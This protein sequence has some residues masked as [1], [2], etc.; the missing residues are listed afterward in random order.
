MH[1][2]QGIVIRHGW[3]GVEPLADLRDTCLGLLCQTA[4]LDQ[5]LLGCVARLVDVELAHPV[6]RAGVEE[7]DPGDYLGRLMAYARMTGWGRRQR[8]RGKLI[9]CECRWLTPDSTNLGYADCNEEPTADPTG[10]QGKS[11]LAL[12]FLFGTV[13]AQQASAAT[14]T[15]VSTGGEQTFTVP[16]GVSSLHV[17]VVG[18]KGGGRRPIG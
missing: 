3:V 18:A 2:E 1:V 11:A 17:L 8:C 9:L 14:Q 4:A 7:P 10:L 15:F 16:A 5:R 13:F 6:A 12:V